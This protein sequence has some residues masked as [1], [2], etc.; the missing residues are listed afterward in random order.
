[1]ENNHFFVE[2][3][4]GKNIRGQV[5]IFIIVGIL[6]VSATLILIYFMGGVK[7]TSPANVNPKA[8][9]DKC[10]K[11]VVTESIN[12]M[13]ANGGQIKPS[14]F[15][16]YE[17]GKYN[18]LCYQADFYQ[19]CYNIHPMLEQQIEQQIVEDT[20]LKVQNCFDSMREELQDK[21]YRVRGGDTKYSIDLLPGYVA[22]NLKKRVDV[23]SLTG[24]SQGLDDFNIRIISPIY[25]MVLTARKI[26]NDESQFCNFEYN[27]EMLLY[28]QYDIRRIDYEDSKIYTIK[29]RKTDSTFKFAVRSCAFPPGI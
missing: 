5:T 1:M 2:I 20:R 17:G 12:K 13:M 25:D 7:T 9:V 4:L 11:D 27:G 10:V 26:V 21:G 15:I 8:I 24:A 29:N 3:D 22:V 14:M 6:V 23:S 16:K 19:G 28:P 18:Y